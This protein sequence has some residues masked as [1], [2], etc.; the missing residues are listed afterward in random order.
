MKTIKE[1]KKSDR[2]KFR[3]ITFK[4]SLVSVPKDILRKDIAEY[5]KS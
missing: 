3:L 4:G 2:P 5:L 1:A